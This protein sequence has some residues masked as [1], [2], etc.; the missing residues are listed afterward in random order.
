MRAKG[1]RG[2]EGVDMYNT[3]LTEDEC[4]Q[5]TFLVGTVRGVPGF[6]TPASTMTPITMGL[7]ELKTQL[8]SIL[9]LQ[10]K[11]ARCSFSLLLLSCNSWVLTERVMMRN[12]DREHGEEQKENKLCESMIEQY[13]PI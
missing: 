4:G 5:L 11:M 1:R 8:G 13:Q 10:G 9:S 6:T 3:V 2:R 7:R 12:E